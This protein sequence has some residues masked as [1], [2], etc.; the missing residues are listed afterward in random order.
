MIPPRRRVTRSP[1]LVL[2]FPH[3]GT[4]PGTGPGASRLSPRGQKRGSGVPSTRARDRDAAFTTAAAPGSTEMSFA[5]TPG[6]VPDPMPRTPRPRAGARG[7][8]AAAM[9]A[10]GGPP[11]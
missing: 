2:E 6:R 7:N 1:L 3:P 9:S 8:A 5:W 10:A 4:R 11:K